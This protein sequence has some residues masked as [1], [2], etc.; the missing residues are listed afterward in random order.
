MR[1]R[2]IAMQFVKWGGPMV[3]LMLSFAWWRS[4]TTWMTHVGPGDWTITLAWGKFGIAY[5]PGIMAMTEQLTGVAMPRGLANI[6]RP[7]GMHW[8][9]S[10]TWEPGRKAVVVPMWFPTIIVAGLSALAWQMEF[11]ARR[12]ARAGNCAKCNYSRV[13]LA[14]TTPCPECGSMKVVA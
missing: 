2:H 5:E 12:R 9:F 7:W 10:G 13:G 3:A 14:S 8:S 6:Q 1:A 11:A 4:G